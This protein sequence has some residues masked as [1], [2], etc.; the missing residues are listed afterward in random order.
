MLKLIAAATTAAGLI[1]GAAFA[2]GSHSHAHTHPHDGHG[3]SGNGF[4]D[5]S[6]DENVAG[7]EHSHEIN[8]VVLNHQHRRVTGINAKAELRER[9]ARARFQ[10]GAG[11]GPYSLAEYRARAEAGQPGIARIQEPWPLRTYRRQ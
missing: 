1:A 5:H 7:V 11:F 2:D 9:R 3:T 10:K 6:H 8:G 4:Y